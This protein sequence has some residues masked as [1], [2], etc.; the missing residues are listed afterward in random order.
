MGGL[1]AVHLGVGVVLK[2]GDSSPVDSVVES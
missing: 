1:W 2:D